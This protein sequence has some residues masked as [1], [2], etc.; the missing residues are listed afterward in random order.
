MGWDKSPKTLTAVLDSLERKGLIVRVRDGQR[1]YVDPN[2]EYLYCGN[3]ATRNKQIELF[4][5]KLYNAKGRK[6]NEKSDS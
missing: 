5:M 1:K 6:S 3:T 2:P 4:R